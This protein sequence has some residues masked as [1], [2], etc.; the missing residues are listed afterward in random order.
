MNKIE[1]MRKETINK[2]FGNGA[3][4]KKK[5]DEFV[6]VDK[7]GYKNTKH[8]FKKVEVYEG[9]I[10]YA[11][12]HTGET[13]GVGVMDNN[14]NIVVPIIYNMITPMIYGMMIIRDESLLLGYINESFKVAITPKY[15]KAYNFLYYSAFVLKGK[16]W[17]LIDKKGNS[18]IDSPFDDISIKGEFCKFRKNGKYGCVDRE[19]NELIPFDYTWLS[20]PYI[21]KNVNTDIDEPICIAKDTNGLY[22]YVTIHG[23]EIAP[24]IFKKAK[25][26]ND[27]VSIAKRL[28]KL[29]EPHDQNCNILGKININGNIITF[30]YKWGNVN[31]FGMLQE[32]FIYNTYDECN[33]NYII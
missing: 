22:G 13:F 14:G 23:E 7:N 19:G 29:N 17:F 24:F 10:P 5:N 12:V 6:F 4:F 32:S 33:G 9:S 20:I 8:K 3:G 25:P 18:L 31:E 11:I 26:F 15:D 28:I 2:G 21:F 1:I 16:D 27:G 30:G